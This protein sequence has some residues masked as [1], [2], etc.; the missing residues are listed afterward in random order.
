MA[1]SSC[2]TTDGNVMCGLP[3]ANGVSACGCSQPTT[4]KTAQT[5]ILE[6][7]RTDSAETKRDVPS[8][9]AFIVGCVASP[10]CTPLYVPLVLFVFAGTPVAAWLGANVGWVYGVLTLLS[11]VS[12]GLALWWRTQKT[13]SVKGKIYVEQ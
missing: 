9:V 13:N 2:T 6:T 12:F 4:T 8:L 7:A 5:T 1:D 11:V 3:D 10:C